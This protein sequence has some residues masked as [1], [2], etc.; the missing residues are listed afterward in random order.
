M[1]KTIIT[2][3][4]LAIGLVGKAQIPV[5]QDETKPIEERVKDALNRMTMEELIKHSLRYCPDYVPF[6][7]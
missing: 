4:A 6:W 7:Q 5:Y 2:L 1:K 3:C